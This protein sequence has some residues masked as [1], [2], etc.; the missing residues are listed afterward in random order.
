MV[1]NLELYDSSGVQS[2]QVSAP[3]VQPPMDLF[4]IHITTLPPL[5]EK[6]MSLKIDLSQPRINLSAKKFE[7]LKPPKKTKDMEERINRALHNYFRRL[8][9]FSAEEKRHLL[10]A[11][12]PDVCQLAAQDTSSHQLNQTINKYISENIV[13]LV[14]WQQKK[15]SDDLLPIYFLLLEL[16]YAYY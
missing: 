1:L 11:K 8:C 5:Q 12:L 14:F 15:E 3:D 4:S 7:D 6:A 2:F 10:E 9:L 16:F 13:V